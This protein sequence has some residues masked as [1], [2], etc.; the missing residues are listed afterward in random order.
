[1]AEMCSNKCIQDREILQRQIK[2]Y[3]ERERMDVLL[4]DG[5]LEFIRLVLDQNK[6]QK[7]DLAK[8]RAELA[9]CRADL[10][11]CRANLENSQADLNESDKYLEIFMQDG[12]RSNGASE[13]GGR[14]TEEEQSKWKLIRSDGHEYL[15]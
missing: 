12:G 3:E 11:E 7:A 13:E 5:Y 1:M 10:A 2:T 14:I 4:Q 8:C 15:M 9:E 6:K